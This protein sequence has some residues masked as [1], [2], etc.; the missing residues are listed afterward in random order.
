MPTLFRKKVV[1]ITS[2]ILYL[3][4]FH[5]FL[6][7][8]AL[9]MHLDDDVTANGIVAPRFIDEIADEVDIIEDKKAPP[10]RKFL[11]YLNNEFIELKS[12]IGDMEEL[13]RDWRNKGK[14]KCVGRGLCLRAH[15]ISGNKKYIC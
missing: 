3:N 15:R 2:V 12:S 11:F 13:G 7:S 5:R 9:E 10:F 14:L 1:F 8:T 4:H 6:R